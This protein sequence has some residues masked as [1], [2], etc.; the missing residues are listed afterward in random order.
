MD[1]DAQIEADAAYAAAIQAS[2]EAGSDRVFSSSA[3]SLAESTQTQVGKLQDDF[4]DHV[5]TLLANTFL[6]ENFKAFVD[7]VVSDFVSA[8]V[9]LI[10]DSKLKLQRLDQMAR[11]SENDAD[12]TEE[13]LD[14]YVTNAS[15]PRKEAL[16]KIFCGNSLASSRITS[17]WQ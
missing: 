13:D 6:E 11:E 10:L 9:D 2:L 4:H 5:G 7:H 1:R 8:T 14:A 17:P 3:S 12:A 15:A 16:I